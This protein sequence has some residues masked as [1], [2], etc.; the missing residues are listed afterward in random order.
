MGIAVRTVHAAIAFSRFEDFAAAFAVVE[1]LTRVRRHEFPLGV[2]AFWARD[3]GE[4][5]HECNLCFATTVRFGSVGSHTPVGLYCFPRIKEAKPGAV[6]G[7]LAAVRRN[8]AI[9]KL[10][11]TP[12]QGTHR[13]LT[14]TRLG[15]SMTTLY[16]NDKS[17]LN[18]S[19]NISTFPSL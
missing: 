19:F 7:R 17:R 6:F 14:Y 13:W 16:S 5:M 8:V 1:V 18:E 4:K 15:P 9:G 2:T 12:C 10:D 11:S 3:C